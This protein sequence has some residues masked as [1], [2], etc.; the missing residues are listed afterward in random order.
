MF[1]G[2]REKHYFCSSF[3]KP[4]VIKSKIENKHYGKSNRTR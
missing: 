2:F 4:E 1:G 3:L